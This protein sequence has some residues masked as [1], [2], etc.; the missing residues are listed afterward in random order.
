MN[1]FKLMCTVDDPSSV[2]TG[3]KVGSND[4]TEVLKAM[5]VSVSEAILAFS[6]EIA[7]AWFFNW[8]CGQ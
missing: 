3:L 1:W 5:M 4:L 6:S 7:V 8:Q 2:V